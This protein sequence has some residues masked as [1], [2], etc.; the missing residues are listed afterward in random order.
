MESVSR[1]FGFRK[2]GGRSV[3]VKNEQAA[4]VMIKRYRQ[5]GYSYQRVADLLN[6]QGVKT[7]LK[8]GVW[9]SKVIRQIS[10]RN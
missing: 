7:K 9:Y 8:H 1:V 6:D 5:Q 3:K 4:I 10:L 2:Y